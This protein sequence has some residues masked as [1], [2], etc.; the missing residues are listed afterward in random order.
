M[1]SI[2]RATWRHTVVCWYIPYLAGL[3]ISTICRIDLATSAQLE[4]KITSMSKRERELEMALREAQCRVS[5]D[6]HPLL[7]Q[8]PEADLRESLDQDEPLSGSTQSASTPQDKTHFVGEINTASPAEVETV[9]DLAGGFGTLSI[10]P[11]RGL[12]VGAEGSTMV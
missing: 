2:R 5:R 8:T 7:V 6:K 12:K 1:L 3:N 4:R 10:T 9:D 11:E